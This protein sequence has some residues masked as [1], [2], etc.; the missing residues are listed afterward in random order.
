MVFV[1]VDTF[2]LHFVS[3]A[4]ETLQNLVPFHLAADT[5][6]DALFFVLKE[7]LNCLHGQ[8]MPSRRYCPIFFGI[9]FFHRFVDSI[10]WWKGSPFEPAMQQKCSRM[11][12]KNCIASSYKVHRR[13]RHQHHNIKCAIWQSFLPAVQNRRHIESS[14]WGFYFKVTCDALYS[15]SGRCSCAL[16]ICHVLSCYTWRAPPSHPEELA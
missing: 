11:L 16:I 8:S 5:S 4:L 15:L 7:R 10:P 9:L 3:L 2:L 12:S 13:L 6:E 1:A 14:E